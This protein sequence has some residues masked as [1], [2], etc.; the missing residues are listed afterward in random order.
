M[1]SNHKKKKN[2]AARKGVKTDATCL[3]RSTIT[4][5]TSTATS[6]SSSTPL[7]NTI[8]IGTISFGLHES[9]EEL[10]Y[11]NE[12]Q[13]EEEYNQVQI[14]IVSL[15]P[16]TVVKQEEQ[17]DNKCLSPSPSSCFTQAE[18]QEIHVRE[19]KACREQEEEEGEEED[20]EDMEIQVLS[21][22]S[23][24]KYVEKT[25]DSAMIAMKII[26]R[27]PNANDGRIDGKAW[28][29]I[30]KIEGEFSLRWPAFVIQGDC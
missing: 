18:E 21:K 3:N 2:S 19:A 29:E 25:C 17:R 20:A 9:V 24:L 28:I 4:S 26:E 22:E 1:P 7:S 5:F 13:E 12:Q 27:Y 6:A 16:P 23:I 8:T 11:E 10:A 30:Q 15:P 14:P